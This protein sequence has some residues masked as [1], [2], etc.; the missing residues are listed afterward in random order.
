[1]PQSRMIVSVIMLALFFSTGARAGGGG[2]DIDAGKRLAEQL[3]ARCHAIEISGNSPFA[4]AP[5]FRILPQRYDLEN[6]AE[7]LAEGIAVGHEAMP[8]FEMSPE[9]IDDF[10]GYLESLN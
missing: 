8:Q 2:V 9:Q 10:L 5:P 7:A 1:M 4:P 6:L 3:C